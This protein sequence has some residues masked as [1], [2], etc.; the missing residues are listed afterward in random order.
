MDELRRTEADCLRR[1][2]KRA[3]RLMLADPKLTRE[4]A[5]G[6]SVS[7]MPKTY[8]KYTNARR[9]LAMMGVL[10]RPLR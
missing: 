5:L 9:Q 7:L 1:I 8:V 6:K 4:L 10:P 3:D 2:A